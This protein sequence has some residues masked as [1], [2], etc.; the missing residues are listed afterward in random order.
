CRPRKPVAPGGSARGAPRP[1]LPTTSRL[2][3]PPA[4]KGSGQGACGLA[5]LSHT[6]GPGRAL[7]PCFVACGRGMAGR[8]LAKRTLAEQTLAE[9]TLAEQTL[10]EQ[11]LAEQTLAERTLARRTLAGRSLPPRGVSR[12]GRGRS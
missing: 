8:T 10:A 4:K 9:Q 7:S 11:T 5:I 6:R 12:R 1:H 2:S 3:R